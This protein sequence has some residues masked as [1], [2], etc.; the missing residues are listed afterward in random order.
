[1]NDAGV[2]S[3]G[4]V[5]GVDL[6]D[7]KGRRWHLVV[8]GEA[9][10]VSRLDGC[11]VE[12]SGAR[13]GRRVFV[14]EWRVLDAG[15]GSAPYIGVLRRYG[16]HWALDDRASGSTLLLAEPTFADLLTHEGQLVMVVGFVDG[17][18]RVRVV[19]WRALSE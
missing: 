3:E 16:S 19:A 5:R 9:A 17:A 1:M 11:V 14:A 10:P 15:D 18:H 2:P 8:T 7:Q 13:L 4:A 12:V 6:V